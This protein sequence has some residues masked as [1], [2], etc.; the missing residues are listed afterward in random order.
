MTPQQT[1]SETF[2]FAEF[3]PGQQ[4]VMETILAGKSAVA[5]F[6]TGAGKSLCYQLPAL[7]EPGMTLVVSPLLS[8]MKDQMEFLQKKNVPAAKLDSGM[9]PEAYREALE[10]ARLGKLKILMIAVERFNNE[11]F[12]TQLRQ[13]KVSLLVVDE[14]HCI[15]EWGHN[16]RP[17]YLKIPLYQK[18]FNIP[19]VL[20]LTATAT[21]DVSKDMCDKFSIPESQ[22]IR[23]GFFRENLY[24]RILPTGEKS[25]E[26]ALGE[27]LSG[28]PE[29]PAIVYVTLQKTAETIA[30]RL[31]QNGFDAVAYHAGMENPEREAVQNRFMAGNSGIVVATIAFGM[32]IDKENIR[33]IIHYDLPKSIEGYSQEI[34]RA[35][36]DDQP[37]LC[38]M[39][40]NRSSVP[41]LENF[42][43]GDTPHLEGIGLVLD[44]IK[45]SPVRTLE[46]RPYTLSRDTDIRLLPL[47]TLLVY[48]EMEKVISPKYT[49]FEE[50]PFKFLVPA[51]EILKNF[52][53]ER[54]TFVET[55]F[56]HSKTAKTWTYPEIDGI[57]EASG[58]DRQRVM[59][60]L[61]YFHEK[62]W[63]DL[64]ARSGVEVYEILNPDFDANKT[65]ALLLKL[66]HEK[67]SRDV[68]RIH[69]MVT[70]FEK[71]QCLA[72]SLSAYF[73]ESLPGDCGR[74]STCLNKEPPV[75]PAMNL[76]PLSGY[77]FPELIQPLKEKTGTSPP[78]HLVTRFLCGIS[79]PR[80]V[81]LKAKAMAEFGL[82]EKYPYKAVEQSVIQNSTGS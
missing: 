21:P 36:R 68:A 22:V 26:K 1:L 15:S 5:I 53:G 48:L 49:F 58:S 18:E 60:A 81:Q 62:A 32:G 46:I 78:V 79:T 67:E 74:C 28:K 4:Q 65:A 19:K 80:L 13:M 44:K 7:H 12:R 59:A 57:I 14:A 17:D 37:S 50:Y 69:A 54:K 75:L 30:N 73:G 31:K 51:E 24:L 3:K 82:L 40:A 64:Q 71:D 42:I 20:L 61:E 72:K 52:Q 47:K 9:T 38:A 8:L 25:K 41:V 77:P 66:F 11:R 34:G 45:K 63:I 76:P 23:T 29:G 2:G 56:S 55:I 33:K 35:G 39:L 70:L 16:F 43:Y 6:P 27:I 10:A